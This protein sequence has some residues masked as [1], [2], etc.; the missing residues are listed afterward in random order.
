VGPPFGGCAPRHAVSLLSPSKLGFRD[1]LGEQRSDPRS[2]R[3]SALKERANALAVDPRPI[4]PLRAVDL[5]DRVRRNHAA[6]ARE[7]PG[8]HRKGRPGRRE[9]LPYIGALHLADEPSLP[10]GDDIAGS[11]AEVDGEGAHGCDRMPALK[12]N[13][14]AA[15]KG[16][17]TRFEGL[18][19]TCHR[20]HL[21]PA[22]GARADLVANLFVFFGTFNL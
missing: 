6:A 12:E 8:L 20:R 3:R 17:L 1:G 2:R 4:T 9:R 21:V 22:L 10:V 5:V 18:E 14:R 16:L 15:V 7:E 11:S 13:T 19:D